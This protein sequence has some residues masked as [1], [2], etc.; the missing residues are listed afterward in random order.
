MPTSGDMLATENSDPIQAGITRRAGLGLLVSALVAGEMS[1]AWA[2]AK[3][4][5]T[6]ATHISLAPTWFDPGETSGLITPYMLLYGLHDAM[7]KPMREGNPAGSLAETYTASADGL[8]YEFVLRKGT[9]FHNGDP[10][11][12]DDVK[13]SFER[14]RGNSH[15]LLHERVASFETPDTQRVV[16]KLKAPWPDFM[17]FYTG[18]TG[19]NWVVPRKYL[20]KVGDAGFKKAPIGAG[21][22]RFVSFE[23]GVELILEA[24]EPY[25]RKSPSIKRIVMKVIP[26]EATRLVAL[27]RGEVDFAYSIR[28]ELAAE[29]KR[30]PNLSLKVAPDGATYWMYFPDQWD[31]QSP[32]HNQKVR[33][34]AHLAIDYKSINDALSLG[35]STLSSSIIPRNFQFF[36]PSPAPVFDPGRA[37]KLMTEAGFPGG[38]DAGFYYC[39]SS[40]A[41]LGEA[42][43]NNL[44][45]IG[46]KAKLR[47]MERAG[48]DKGFSEKRFRK[49]IIQGSSAAFGNAATRLSIF[50]VGGGPYVYGSYPDIDAM[51]AQQVNEVDVEKRTAILHKIQQ[52]IYEKHMFVNLWQLGFLNA[53]GPR[54][55][56]S[57]IGLIPGFVY[58]GPFEDM[59]LKDS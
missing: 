39:D 11:T 52:L 14:Y 13:F 47:P 10:V 54:V 56:E 9:T 43:L 15:A 5:L 26:D 34:A 42:A 7:V 58:T 1:D 40:Y 55:G 53:A 21:P 51:Y 30:S 16:I 38:F 8:T 59:T 4:Q 44:A 41:N 23:P 49:G 24:Y 19:A 45:A 20:E 6:I 36:W 46:I 57:G 18:A 32:W 31:P 12:S 27:K 33:Q 48:F 35:Y 50:V 3:G 22:Y 29:V 2:A 28:G 37:M 25:W 17:T